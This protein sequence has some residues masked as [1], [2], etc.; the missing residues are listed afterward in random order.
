M[1]LT[2]DN[3]KHELRGN[4]QGLTNLQIADLFLKPVGQVTALTLMMFDAEEIK[5]ELVPDIPIKK[6]IYKTIEDQQ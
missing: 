1:S 3:V 6:Y 2:W 5:R 4:P